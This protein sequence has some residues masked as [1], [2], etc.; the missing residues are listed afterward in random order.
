MAVT[1]EK[2]LSTCRRTS[3][4]VDESSVRKRGQVALS[5]NDRFPV[6]G[7]SLGHLDAKGRRFLRQATVG[8]R[9]QIVL[10]ED[11]GAVWVA[12]AAKCTQRRSQ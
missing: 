1:R 11:L 5:T 3:R 4:A 10:Q 7:A 12:V 8:I 9:L 6:I 2:L